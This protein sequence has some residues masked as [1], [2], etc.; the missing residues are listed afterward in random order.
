MT[1]LL[2]LAFLL[3]LPCDACLDPDVDKS[4]AC[5]MHIAAGHVHDA[6]L[7]YLQLLTAPF[8]RLSSFSIFL[9]LGGLLCLL[10]I[11]RLLD[12]FRFLGI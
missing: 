5:A 8:L 12:A 3:Q 6:T 10:S 9:S 1:G 4:P 11:R 7:L 2:C